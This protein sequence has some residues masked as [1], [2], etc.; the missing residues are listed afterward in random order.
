MS[1]GLKNAPLIYQSV[2]NNCLWGFKKQKSIKIFLDFLGLDPAE[3]QESGRG[4]PNDEVKGL[5]ASMTVFQRYIDMPLPIGPVLGRSSY[6]DDIAHGAKTRN[7]RCEDLD[8]L[9]YRLLCPKESL[10][11]GRSHEISAEG[12][13]ATPK[14]A[15]GVMDLPFPKSHKGVLSFLGSLNYYH[16]FIEDFPVVAAVLYELSEAQT[17]QGRDLSRAHQ[18]FELLKR[19]IVATPMLRH[20]D[21]P[22]PFVVIPHANRWAACAVIG[23]EHDE[24]IQ[25]VRYT[26]RDL[27]DAELRYHIAEKVV[28]AILRALQVFRTI[29][30]GLQLIIYT[31]YYALKWSKSADGRCVPWGVTH[32]HWDI[33]IRKV[34]KDE[35][36]LA[37]IMGAGITPREHLDEAVETLIPLKFGGLQ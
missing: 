27:N 22:K 19:K 5:T 21:I 30:E 13:R 37:A 29:L 28:V 36:G 7:Q 1:F 20:P 12:I 15:K 10:E 34:Q 3:S 9:L 31:R 33:E 25:R 16:K 35:D 4:C 26:G 18:S 24:K 32:S 11:N 2:I 14:V 8:T 6:I 23:Q 17:R